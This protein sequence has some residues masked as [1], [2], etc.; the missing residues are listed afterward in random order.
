MNHLTGTTIRRL[1]RVNDKTIRALAAE[2]NITVQ[3]VREVRAH[4]VKGE[5][6][7]RD[8]LYF[9]GG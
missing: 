4:G 8:W 5:A 6:F 2:M 1:M 7:V 3:R 9:L